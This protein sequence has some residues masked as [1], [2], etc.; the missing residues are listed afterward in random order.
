MRSLNRK[1]L[2][3]L[4]ALWG[5]LVVVSFLGLLR[6]NAID[7]ASDELLEGVYP[8]SAAALEV[9]SAIYNAYQNTIVYCAYF[10]ADAKSE[11][12]ISSTGMS[13]ELE[14]M[15]YEVAWLGESPRRKKE[16]SRE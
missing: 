2:F 3:Y 13:E 7:Q 14:H 12:H 1:I 10:D 6:L 9:E 11:T 15:K 4:L 16:M 5:G 8:A